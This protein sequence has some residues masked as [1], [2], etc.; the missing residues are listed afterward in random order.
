MLEAGLHATVPVARVER[1][2][3]QHH[4]HPEQRRDAE[5]PDAG[6][7][8]RLDGRFL[9]VDGVGGRAVSGLGEGFEEGVQAGGVGV[10]L[11]LCT[12]EGEVDGGGDNAGDR[13]EEA[14]YQ[15]GASGAAHAFY[16]EGDGGGGAA[17]VS[18]TCVAVVVGT[19]P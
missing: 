4:L 17:A 11:D 5:P 15:P 3:E 6:A 2:A 9:G 1:D 8:F 12:A 16:G 10:E 18:G 19:A 14:F 7:A 13:G